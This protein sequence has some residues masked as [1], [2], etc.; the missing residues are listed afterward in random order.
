MTGKPPRP[1]SIEYVRVV[2]VV[3]DDRNAKSHDPGIA[4]SIVRFGFV[5]SVVRDE[6]TGRLIAGHGRLEA[7]NALEESGTEPPEGIVVDDTGAWTLPVTVGWAS[8]DDAEAGAL[9]VGLNEWTIRGGWD[10][11]KLATLLADVRASDDLLV[12]LAGFDGDR[13][14]DLLAGVAPPPTLDQLA[15]EYGEPDDEAG[16]PVIRVLVPHAVYNRWAGLL[17]Q[18]DDGKLTDAEK[19][20]QLVGLAERAWRSGA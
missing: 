19:V 10:D 17:A 11:H 14:D 9:L 4:H 3:G 6:R 13:L 20:E 15:H 2:D 5:E 7:L 8:K 1:R 12:G 18:L 16:W